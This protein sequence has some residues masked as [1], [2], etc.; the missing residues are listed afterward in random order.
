MRSEEAFLRLIRDKET[1]YLYQRRVNR[2]RITAACGTVCAIAVVATILLSGNFGFF[3]P[4]GDFGS[5]GHIGEISDAMGGGAIRS[6][7]ADDGVFEQYD[8]SSSVNQNE[9][10]SD[11]MCVSGSG[12]TIGTEAISSTSG[13]TTSRVELVEGRPIFEQIFL[14]KD[15]S[16]RD[17]YA[18]PSTITIYPAGEDASD[19]CLKSDE[20]D[21]MEKITAFCERLLAVGELGEGREIPPS[22]WNADLLCKVEICYPGEITVTLMITA[23]G[24][25][26]SDDLGMGY[27]VISPKELQMLDDFIGSLQ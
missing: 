10:A 22:F 1:E 17:N 15:L 19:I 25:A 8:S 5:G 20:A 16:N 11:Q 9:A 6:E 23:E 18:I 21:G 27:L 13:N 4:T 14:P 3:P 24:I 26:L 7:A 12:T 2:K